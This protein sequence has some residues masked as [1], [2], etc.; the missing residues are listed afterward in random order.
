[1]EPVLFYGVPSG[2]SF[3]SI[4]A[5]EWLGIPYKLCRIDM[6]ECSVPLEARQSIAGHKVGERGRLAVVH[7]A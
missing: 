4:V 2:C 1:M 7:A 5:L 3:G 6:P